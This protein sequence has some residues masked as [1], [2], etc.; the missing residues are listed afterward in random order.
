MVYT[1]LFNNVEFLGF[2]LLLSIFLFFKKKN[3]EITGSFPFLYMMLFKT[4]FGLDKMKSWS[5]KHPRVFMFLAYVSVIIGVIGVVLSFIFMIWQLDY[6]VSKG[7][8]QGGGFV[9]PLK[10]DSGM[11]STLPVFYVPFGYWII[12]LFVLAVVHEFAHGVIAERFGVK[13]KSSGFAFLGI[14]LPIMPAAFVEPDDKSLKKKTL[15]EQIAVF[16]AGSTSNFIFGFLFFM[17][18]M[19]VAAPFID[20]TM[21]IGDIE[22]ANVMNQS[23]L[24]NYNVNSGKLIALDGVYDK[25]N[26]YSNM[27]NLSVNQSVVLTIDDGSGAKEYTVNT[28]ENPNRDGYGML[29]ISG[30]NKDIVAK[31]EYSYLGN[32]PLHFEKS[33]FWIWFLNVGIGI[34][35]LLPIW[36]TDGGQ[37]LKGILLKYVKNEK[38]ALRINTIVSF[39]SLF[40]IIFTLKPNL[41]MAIIGLF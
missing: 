13:I 26:M 19:F 18:W 21:E 12:A 41:L 17:V 11:D 39:A 7:I 27:F 23:D 1:F 2:I 30:L 40:L 32:F 10:T 8:T 31:K 38:F 24:F 15:F 6:I 20:N 37:I 9:L 33:L 16:G 3:L 35:N 5:D 14:L 34:M 36:I 22:F 4:R 29:G 25:E 28:F